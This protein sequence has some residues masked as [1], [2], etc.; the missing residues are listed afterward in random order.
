MT[1]LRA[2]LKQ[3]GFAIVPNVV[4]GDALRQL[5]QLTETIE[6][7]PDRR[8]GGLRNPFDRIA[9]LLNAVRSTGV[10][11]LVRSLF[12]E[13]PFVVRSILF[14]K[15]AD[16]NWLVRWHR[17]TTIAVVA[18]VDAEGFGPWSIK[19]GLQHTRPPRR[20]LERMATIRLHLDDCPENNGPLRVMLG[21]HADEGV[22]PDESHAATC[23]VAAGDAVL[24]KP[25]TLHA[26]SK[27]TC[28]K[29]RRVLHLELSDSD[30]PGG[31]DWNERVWLD[32]R[33]DAFRAHPAPAQSRP[34]P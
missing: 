26:S 19:E 6:G 14:D 8:V 1:E 15:N 22:E 27:A 2:T 21:S 33:R 10:P 16:A 18:R 32:D 3:D 29:R 9:G 12:D 7:T 34:Q 24:M 25:L 4:G 23:C 31:L 17:D 30:L 28:P 13:A 5:R 11:D 20:I